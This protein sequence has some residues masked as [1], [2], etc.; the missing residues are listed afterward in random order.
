MKISNTIRTSRYQS[1]DGLA[2]YRDPANIL[3]IPAWIGFNMRNPAK[4]AVAHH[5]FMPY[6]VMAWAIAICMFVSYIINIA[7]T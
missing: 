4:Q 7:N 2:I 6:H 1:I 5:T 3:R